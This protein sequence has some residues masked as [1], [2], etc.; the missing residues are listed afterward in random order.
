M[1]YRILIVIMVTTIVAAQEQNSHQPS[2]IETLSSVCSNNES[3]N[4]T[5]CFNK[6]CQ[7]CLK[8]DPM[9]QTQQV[10]L[11]A[12]PQVVTHFISIIQNPKNTQTLAQSLTAIAAQIISIAIH[13]FKRNELNHE[14]LRSIISSQ[15]MLVRSLTCQ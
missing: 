13:A 12:I 3:C 2:P 11:A 9:E 5:Q 10:V 4:C 14:Q 6:K 15:L 8:D 7:A 1:N